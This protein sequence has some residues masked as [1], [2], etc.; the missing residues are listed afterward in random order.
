MLVVVQRAQL[1]ACLVTPAERDA[2]VD[3]LLF[4]PALSFPTAQN[5]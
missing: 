5:G 4:I 2:T 1:R 3:P